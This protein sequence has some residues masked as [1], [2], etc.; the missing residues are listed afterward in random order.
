MQ[1]EFT[2][3]YE[4][5]V[6]AIDAEHKTFFDYVNEA[7]RAMDLPHDEAVKELKPLL[8]KLENYASA[9]IAHEEAYMRKMNDPGLGAQQEAHKTFARKVKEMSSRADEL[10][11]KDLG[12]IF[13]FMAKWLKGHILAMDQLIGKSASN[14][15]FVMTEEFFT[16]IQFVDEEHAGLFDIIGRVH[17]TIS[18]DML[19]DR[20][21]AIINILDELTEYTER[22][23]A[24]E[25]A[26][27]AKIQ[28]AGIAGQKAAHAA[29]VDKIREID[30]QEVSD[31]G[32]DQNEYLKSLVSFLN[33][34]LVDHILKMDKKIPKA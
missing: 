20:F 25:E 27:M 31:S 19:H 6:A 16:G 14:D 3:D 9:H 18:N 23:F 2:K 34:W 29:F 33:N 15:K 4:I 30:L 26:Y 11:L 21:D 8:V 22:H 5:G 17:D 10:E 13:I 12:D 32:D 24:D 1:Y 28:Y 7:V